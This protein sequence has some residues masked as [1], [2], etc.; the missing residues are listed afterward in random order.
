M[1]QPGTNCTIAEWNPHYAGLTGIVGDLLDEIK[2]IVRIDECL[3]YP[4]GS[5]AILPISELEEAR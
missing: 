1:I 2:A 4:N 3:P 5:W